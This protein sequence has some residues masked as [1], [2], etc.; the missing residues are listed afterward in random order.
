[1]GTGTVSL[2][3]NGGNV[4]LATNPHLLPFLTIIE[5]ILEFLYRTS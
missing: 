2:E 3:Q 1:M 4:K 5:V